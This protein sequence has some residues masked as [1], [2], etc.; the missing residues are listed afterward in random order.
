MCLKRNTT[1]AVDRSNIIENYI[2]SIKDTLTG[3]LK[4]GEITALPS[5]PSDTAAANAAQAYTEEYSKDISNL[6]GIY[7]SSRDT[8]T[9][10]HTDKQ[11]IGKVTRPDE[12]KL[13]QLH[14]ALNASDDGVYNTGMIISPVTGEY[15]F[16]PDETKI[17]TAAEEAQPLPRSFRV[18]QTRSRCLSENSPSDKKTKPRC[19]STNSEAI[20]YQKIFSLIPI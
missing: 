3:Y 19:C 1:A 14:D 5:D 17:M 10:T 11:H 4:A 6:E 2:G 15:I 8:K 16:H 13:K 7:A 9:L 12:D 20:N 18:R